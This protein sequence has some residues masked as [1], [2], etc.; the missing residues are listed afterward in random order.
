METRSFSDVRRE[1]GWV[2]REERTEVRLDGRARRADGSMISVSIHDLSREGC[3]IE[4]A[5]TLM[6]IGEWLDIEVAAIQ[7]FRAQVRWS[8]LGSAGVQFH[9]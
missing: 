4:T 7:N 3:R 8:L 2:G 6:E 5:D 9:D 1:P